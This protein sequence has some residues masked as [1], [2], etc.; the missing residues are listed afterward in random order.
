M[1]EFIASGATIGVIAG[2]L[3]TSPANADV[4]DIEA[5]AAVRID[6]ASASSF[7]G[8]AMDSAGDFD[9]DGYDDVILGTHNVPAGIGAAHIVFGGP[10][11]HSGVLG[12]GRTIHIAGNG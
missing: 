4:V 8:S 10:G 11:L 7:L 12:S 1:R 5:A 6:G 3:L 9:G 2:L